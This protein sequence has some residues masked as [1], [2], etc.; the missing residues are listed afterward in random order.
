MNK[1]LHNSFNNSPLTGVNFYL[2]PLVQSVWVW[3]GVV[4][5]VKRRRGWWGKVGGEKRK[6]VYKKTSDSSFTV[7]IDIRSWIPCVL[8]RLLGRLPKQLLLSEMPNVTHISCLMTRPLVFLQSNYFGTLANHMKN[9][10]PSDVTTV[11]FFSH[12]SWC[13]YWFNVIVRWTEFEAIHIA[14]H[15]LACAVYSGDLYTSCDFI[16]FNAPVLC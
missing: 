1:S 14:G 5:W 4:M 6:S 3:L 15:I 11:F 7:Q 12:L 2:R 13:P 8:Y 16:S 9:H 10:N